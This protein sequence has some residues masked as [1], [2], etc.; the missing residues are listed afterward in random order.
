MLEVDKLSKTYLYGEEALREIS[1]SLGEGERVSVLAE[2]GAGKTTLLKIIAGVTSPGEGKVKLDGREILSLPPKER[3]IKMVYDGEGYFK[4]RTVKY[5]LSYPLRLRKYPKEERLKRVINAAAEYG[6]GHLLDEYVFRLSDEDRVRMLLSR[7][8][9]Y[10]ARLTLL[11]DPF[12]MLKAGARRR[13]FNE[14]LPKMI[15][16]TGAAVFA[17]DIPEE[18]F[19]FSDRVLTLSNGRIADDGDITHYRN[20]PCDLN[21]D[22]MINSNRN[23]T[24]LPVSGIGTNRYVELGGR[25]FY[26]DTAHDNAAVSYKVKA[27]GGSTDNNPAPEIYGACGANYRLLEDLTKTTGYPS[28]SYEIDTDSVF[29]YDIISEK[30]LTIR[31]VK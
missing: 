31:S 20:D 2:E 14:L 12:A 24:I 1:F 3:G 7:I 28:D 4:R 5:N 25:A 22:K 21:S 17:T 27:V 30:R 26:V 23:F 18:A 8:G 16:G 13:L 15:S 19:A 9:L 6:V 29:V 11:D 10:E